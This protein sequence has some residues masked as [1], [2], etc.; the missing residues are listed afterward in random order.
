M[1]HLLRIDA[2]PRG[3]R[4]ISRVLTKE[5]AENWKANHPGGTVAY[6]DI[7]HH[8]PPHVNE[9]W[10]AGAFS[11]PDART[12]EQIEA[13]K[14]S[15]EL[16]AEVVAADTLVLGVPMYNFN[17]PSG[18]KAWVDQIIRI[19]VT[20]GYDG[21]TFTPLVSGKKV[22]VIQAR[23]GSFSGDSPYAPY[24]FQEPWIRTALGF[25]GL[26]DITFITAENLNGSD[27]GREAALEN[28]RKEIAKA[29][30]A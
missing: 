26:T 8:Q 22:V 24:D 3:D 21:K 30:A 27:A 10:I 11:P 18:F 15:D 14:T 17:V 25:I 16:V 19:G 13:L 29:T 4:S 5:F 7:G 12:P 1:P 20:V 9:D 28:A 6:R 2:S 23:G